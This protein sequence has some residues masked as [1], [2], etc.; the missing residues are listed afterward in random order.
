MTGSGS[1]AS[2]SCRGGGRTDGSGRLRR[3][4]HPDFDIYSGESAAIVPRLVAGLAKRVVVGVAAAKHHTAA[5]TDAGEVWTWGSNRDGRL[6]YPAVDTQPTPRRH[7]WSDIS[8]QPAGC[9]WVMLRIAA[10]CILP[11]LLTLRGMEGLVEQ[12]NTLR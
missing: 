8:A 3:A 1:S 5:V 11:A 6:G 2:R 10:T 12:Q 7:A 4:G 9:A